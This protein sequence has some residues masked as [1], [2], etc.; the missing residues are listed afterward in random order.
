MQAQTHQGKSCPSFPTTCPAPNR[1]GLQMHYQIWDGRSQ[2]RDGIHA[3][4]DGLRH[5]RFTC[6][7]VF[8]AAAG[9]PCPLAY[10]PAGGGC[11]QAGR[12]T[13]RELRAAMAPSRPG[14]LS[15]HSC[16]H[17][18]TQTH[19]RGLGARPMSSSCSSHL[20]H[21]TQRGEQI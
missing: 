18:Q 2:W 4:L 10:D 9:L 1:H 19:G 21:D 13:A 6:L 20:A 16:T 11:G 8:A 7:P 14:E 12:E 3:L 5:S 15:P 17:T